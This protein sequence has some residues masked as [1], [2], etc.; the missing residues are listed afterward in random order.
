MTKEQLTISLNEVI[1]FFTRAGFGLKVPV[2]VAEDFARSN[3]WIA[4]N[5]FD[6]SLCSIG[7]LDNIECQASD[8]EI[9]FKKTEHGGRFYCPSDLYLS[10][11]IAS[12]S[13]VDRINLGIKDNQLV[14]KNFYFPILVIAAMGANKC[15]SLQAFWLDESNHE[16]LVRFVAEG[17]WEVVSSNSQPIE[18]SKGANM[19]I[20]PVS[21]EITQPSNANVKRYTTANEKEKIL[22]NGVRV[23][24][25]WQGIYDYFSRC[26][27]K[28]TVESRASGAG[29]GMVDTD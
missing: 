18:L 17:V 28:S 8:L 10:S 11:L 26:L 5:G 15:N 21:S 1:F 2:G 7:A 12:V 3:V 25:K 24:E 22:Q 9:L 19:I 20:Q 29:A 27:V 6:P 16:Y 23:G 4:E 13:V 14:M